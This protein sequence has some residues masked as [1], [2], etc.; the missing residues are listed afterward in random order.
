MVLQTTET[1]E[2]HESSILYCNSILCRTKRGCKKL[3]SELAK[4][5]VDIDRILN[6]DEEDVVYVHWTSIGM[7]EATA[8]LYT[9]EGKPSDQVSGLARWNPAGSGTLDDIIYPGEETPA[10][11]SEQAR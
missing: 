8:F 10:G 1:E 9:S 7:S 11:A 3:A 4:Q 2:Y 5:K 6:E